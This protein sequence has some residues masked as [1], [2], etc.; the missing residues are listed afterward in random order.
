MYLRQARVAGQ[1]T[2]GTPDALV[3]DA[4]LTTLAGFQTAAV[5]AYP[6]MSAVR[7]TEILDGLLGTYT[8]CR[9]AVL[10]LTGEQFL[11]VV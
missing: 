7:Q 2:T 6:G 1:I 8:G 5:P 10:P 11:C 4:L 3:V 9:G